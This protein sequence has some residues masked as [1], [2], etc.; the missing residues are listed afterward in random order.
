MHYFNAARTAARHSAH[1]A[2]ATHHEH[3]PALLALMRHIARFPLLRVVVVLLALAGTGVATQA[4]ADG[5]WCVSR[6]TM[7]FGDHAVGSNTTSTFTV[8]NCGDQAWS[9]TDVSVNAATGPAFHVNTTCVTGMSLAPGQTCT[10]TVLFAPLVTGQTSGALWLRN[11]T[12]TPTQLVTFYGRGV[13]AQAATA[14]LTFIPA[15][16][17]FPS[18]DIGKQSAAMTVELHNLGPA[19]LTPSAMVL[20]GP[21][22]YD[23]IG[24]PVTC[25]VGS[26]I[27][28]GQSCLLSLYFTP[29]APGT[30]RA[31]LVIDSPQL[32]SLA[33]MQISGVGAAAVVAA[34]AL[35][36]PVPNMPTTSTEVLVLLALALAIVGW[37]ALRRRQ[38]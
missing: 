10:T 32:A 3:A 11:T 38:S 35:P 21:E 24:Y 17:M 31:N 2:Q 12:S 22:V 25:Q 27:P 23:F 33:I 13:D 6:D 14:T 4:H 1:P 34:V 29:Q 26:P 36:P 37:W 30:R 20:N 8:T 28:A 5:G 9:F 7:F 18:Q 15:A 16:A 19:A